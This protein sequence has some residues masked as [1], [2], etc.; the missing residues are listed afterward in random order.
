MSAPAKTTIVGGQSDTDEATV[1]G[2]T[3]V[4]PPT[5]T[6]TF[7]E[8]GP[9][10]TPTSSCAS[11]TQVGNPVTVTTS[12]HSGTAASAP[13]TPPSSSSG[14]WCFRAVYNGDSNYLSSTDDSADECFY[15]SGPLAIT[16][17]S[18]L[19]SGIKKAPYSVQLQAAGGV[20]PYKW[21]YKGTLPTGLSL[22]SSGLL[23][24]TPKAK[25]TYTFTVKVKDSS[26]PNEKASESVSITVLK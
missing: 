14:Y 17:T 5:G 20:G 25:G 19:P 10:A 16:T 6:V 26:T 22:S 4:G 23:S 24:G 11:G 21:S 15:E 2:N 12:G 8:C 1:T 3:P 18:P 9:T 7:Y 13:F